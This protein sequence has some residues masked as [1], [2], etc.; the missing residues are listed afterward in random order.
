MFLE[1]IVNYRYAK[2]TL[3]V[4]TETNK[5]DFFEKTERKNIAKSQSRSVSE[6]QSLKVR[7]LGSKF[8]V[9]RSM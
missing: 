3:F 6:S 1:H 9:L 8:F 5:I 7:V 4:K 2:I